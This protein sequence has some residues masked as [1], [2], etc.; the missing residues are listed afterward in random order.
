MTSLAT[1]AAEKSK[2]KRTCSICTLPE[3][4]L[5]EVNGALAD[6]IGNRIIGHWLQDE[7]GLDVNERAV[8]YHRES[9]H[10]LEDM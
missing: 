6:G 3:E 10:H 1:Y 4:I 5:E 8:K 9:R 7:Q 2:K